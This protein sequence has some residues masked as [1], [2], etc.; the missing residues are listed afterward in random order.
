MSYTLGQAAKATGKSKS[1]LQ[2]AIKKGRIS[3]TQ[4]ESGQYQID[5]S[6]LHRVYPPISPTDRTTEPL[7][8]QDKTHANA[9]KIAEITGLKAR[10]EVMEQLV[11]ELRGD[12]EKAER[13][14]AE[15]I[16]REDTLRDDLN[17]WRGFAFDAQQRLKA[18]EAPKPDPMRGDIIEADRGDHLQAPE[19][20]AQ[21][22]QASKKGFFRRL[23]GG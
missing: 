21:E 12:K 1:T 11:S 5:P 20:A 18:L 8:E 14:E 15:A 7:S 2:V 23:F 9:E 22:K 3:A 10:L 4:D 19:T 6:E 16:R 13:R 17:Q